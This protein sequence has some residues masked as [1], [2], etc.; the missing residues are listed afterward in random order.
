MTAGP[1]NCSLVFVFSIVN[2][3]H[4]THGPAT[5]RN[6]IAGHDRIS[7]CASCIFGIPR[8]R[9]FAFLARIPS[10]YS[11]LL[12]RFLDPQGSGFR[13]PRLP[14]RRRLHGPGQ[15]GNGPRWRLEIWL[16]AT[17]RHPHQ[18]PDGDVSPGSLGEARHR[19]RARPRAGLPRTLFAPHRFLPLGRLRNCH[20]CV[21]SRR[22]PWLRRRSETALRL[23]ASC[24]RS[25]YRDGCSDR[26]RAPGPGLPPDRSLRCNADRFD[27]RLLRVRNFLRAAAMARSRRRFHSARGNPAQ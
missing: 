22:S 11:F 13:R 15:L 20:R 19:L 16:H 26:S 4:D 14:R 17:Q 1:I 5:T 23:A 12:G 27:C 21:R 18:Q 6:R 7:L 9:S 8:S 2:S 25:H 24:R 3:N 10:H